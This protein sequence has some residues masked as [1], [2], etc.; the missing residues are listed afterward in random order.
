SAQT[1]YRL[2]ARWLTALAGL[3]L[4]RIGVQPSNHRLT[5][6]LWLDQQREVWVRKAPAV[7]A[8]RLSDEA[9]I[10]RELAL[11]GVASAVVDGKDGEFAYVAVVGQG[12]PMNHASKDP[13]VLAAMARVLRAVALAG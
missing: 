2:P 10:Q 12:Q 3:R 5:S 1:D 13:Y 9:R 11:P 8:A 6:G 4:G 7:D